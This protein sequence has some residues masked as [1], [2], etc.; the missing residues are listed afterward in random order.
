M[1]Y[2]LHTAMKSTQQRTDEV[3]QLF[4]NP[5]PWEKWESKLVYG[6]IIIAVFSLTILG[7]LINQF[8]LQ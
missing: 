3:N 4:T 8:L 1:K 5:E 6:S 2:L 7:I